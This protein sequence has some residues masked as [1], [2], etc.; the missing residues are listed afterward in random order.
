MGTELQLLGEVQAAVDGRLFDLG[1]PKQR[2]VLAALA[3]EAGKLVP[4]GALV[5][6][7][8]G[9]D[10]PRSASDALYSYLSRLR[11]A[12]LPAPEVRLHRRSGGYLLSADPDTVDLRRFERLAA[13]AR[14]A[15]DEG[16]ALSLYEQ[17]LALWRGE[18]LA[19][20]ETPWFEQIRGALCQQRL[21]AEMDRADVALRLGRHCALLPALQQQVA[22]HPLD[23]RLA[24]QLML[25][26]YLDGRGAEALRQYQRMRL[27]L[28]AEL[29]ISP[30]PALRRLHE[31]ILTDDPS[32]RAQATVVA[33]AATASSA[34]APVPRQLPPSPRLFI[35][36][37]PELACLGEAA[38]ILLITGTGGIGKTT[39]ALHWAHQNTALFPDGQLYVDLHG[40]DPSG[41]A[42][43]P[44]AA[45]R[46]FLGALGVPHDAIP[47]DADAQMGL[48]RSLTA[49]R[50]LLFFLDNAFDSAQ[51][52]PLLPG[53]H[54]CTVLITSRRDL[55]TLVTSHGARSVTLDALAP[56]E[57]RRLL[58]GHLGQ[59]RAQA[60]PGA[61]DSLLDACAGLPLALS[62]LG[63]RAAAQPVF[64][65][66]A[67]TRELQETATR[68]DVL[69]AGEIKAN[70]RAVFSCSY[71][72][73]D[74]E[75]A[76]AFGLLGLAP[77]PDIGLS[78]AAAL[79]GL[80]RARTRSVL[81]TLEQVHL[82][83]QH[84]PERYRMHDLVR[85][86]AAECGRQAQAGQGDTSALTRLIDHYLQTACAGERLLRPHGESLAEELPTVGTGTAPTSTAAALS[87][88]EAEHA[89]LLATHRLAACQGRHRTTVHLAWA[90]DTYHYRRGLRG[91]NLA[92]WTAA[93]AAAEALDSPA[94]V[95]LAHRRLGRAHSVMHRHAEAAEH[96][97]WSLRLA[98]HTDRTADQAYTQINLAWASELRGEDEQSL[99]HTMHALRLF[100]A[101]GN[102][103]WE[104]I[105]LNAVGWYCA[106]LGRRDDAREH[107]ERALAINR[108][109]DNRAAE[110]STLDSLGYIAYCDGDYAQAAAH[111]R[112]TLALYQDFGDQ[113]SEAD[114]LVRLGETYASGGRPAEARRVLGQALDLYRAQ[115][116]QTA[117]AEVLQRLGGLEHGE[118]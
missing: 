41:P 37:A 20:M 11:G 76:D 101:L 103:T 63:A 106:R 64:P 34:A 36:R 12:L 18:P 88:F 21:E 97:H 33:A 35:G 107:C 8:W 71:R 74:A 105:A 23:E 55:A 44:S 17:A 13:Q 75:A 69:D 51:V 72:A 58:T 67:L 115:H 92:G 3:L 108:R 114:T 40:F 22:A 14:A 31:R 4:V 50:R 93:L 113:Y 59:E 110:A 7:V 73:I 66:T 46:A 94:L 49:G 1:P 118:G 99:L 98:E 84:Q 54:T 78:A 117:T 48:L 61:V 70:V 81:R 95:I 90:M 9:T 82:I 25:A 60:E 6:R 57:S 100:T 56:P 29:G 89:C 26:L 68:L 109:I 10:P 52:T 91:E 15:E 112:G 85:H 79:T 77:G 28:S 47:A 83:Q 38:P 86:Y 43:D 2:R 24:G 27:R 62:I 16:S 87:W 80:P 42:L 65:L 39:L 19:G 32:L 111:Y 102:T 96:L 30:D 104:A 45:L 116:R 5:T 53:G